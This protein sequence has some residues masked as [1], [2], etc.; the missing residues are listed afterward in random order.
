MLEKRKGREP[1][2]PICGD[3]PKRETQSQTGRGPRTYGI[4]NH[5]QDLKGKGPLLFKTSPFKSWRMG[6]HSMEGGAK[7]PGQGSRLLKH[8][9]EAC[10]S[11]PQAEH[12]D[13]GFA[14]PPFVS[15]FRLL[16][17]PEQ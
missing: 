10:S 9:L 16:L 14:R 5:R 15:S 3:D 4:A 11:C 12:C 1:E 6:E 17:L 2:L 8:T 13:P 7:A